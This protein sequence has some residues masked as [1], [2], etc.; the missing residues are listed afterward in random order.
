MCGREVQILRLVKGLASEIAR[1]RQCVK[2]QNHECLTW[3]L[4]LLDEAGPGTSKR[5]KAG[6]GT[7][8]MTLCK[9]NV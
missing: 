8:S 1:G 3:I 7:F 4:I 2:E 9:N 6:A 5:V